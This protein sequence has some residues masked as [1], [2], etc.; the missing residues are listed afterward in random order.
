VMIEYHE[1]E[2]SSVD[3]FACTALY[4]SIRIIMPSTNRSNRK[5]VRVS[6]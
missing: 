1:M 3:F 6:D 4:S 2:L 5:K